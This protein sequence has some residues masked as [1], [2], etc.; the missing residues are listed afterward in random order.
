MVDIDF[1]VPSEKNELRELKKK[2]ES[3]G[4]KNKKK[5]KEKKEK[6]VVD[7]WASSE[8]ENKEEINLI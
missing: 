3:E 6:K 2:K 5:S 8:D 1:I 7:D 4:E